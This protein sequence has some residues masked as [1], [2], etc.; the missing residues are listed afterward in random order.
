MKL[1]PVC[2][3][4]NVIN[5]FTAVIYTLA[6]LVANGTAC[7]LPLQCGYWQGV[8]AQGYNTHLTREY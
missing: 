3:V 7:F 4:V 8:V 1:P 5:T 2:T 6:S